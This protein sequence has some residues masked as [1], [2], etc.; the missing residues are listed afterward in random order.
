MSELASASFSVRD[1][2]RSGNTAVL[3]TALGLAAV[4]AVQMLSI[5]TGVHEA[6]STDDAM[7]LVEVRDLING[8][9]WFDLHQYRLNP[10]GLL[11]HWSRVIDFP[12]SISI[13]AL[14]PLLGM[15]RAESVTLFVWPL[16]LFG[17]ALA[18]I[19]AIARQ[20]SDGA[21][22]SQVGAVILAMLARPALVHFRPGAIDHHNAQ[23]DLLLLLILFTLQIERSAVKAALAGVA[24][25]LSLA[26]GVE[27]LPPIAAICVAVAGLFIWRGPAV[28]R[29]VAAFAIAL[30]GSSLVLALA[31]LPFPAM[32]APVCD[33]LGG[34]VL[35]LTIGGGIGLASMAAIDRYRSALWLRLVTGTV[36]GGAL[37]SAFIAL[38]GGCLEAP[39]AQLDPLVA[40]LWLDTV[41]ETISLAKMLRLGPEDVLG[42]YALPLI[43][44]GLAAGAL[45]RSKPHDRFRWIVCI[46][47]LIA[48]FGISVWE[49][50]GAGGAAMVA[51]P[52][53]AAAVTAIWPSL[54]FGSS[55]ALLALAGSS[56]AFAAFGVAAKPLT[57]LAFKADASAEET[58]KPGCSSVSDVAWMARLPKGRVMAPID[59][60]P[61]ILGTTSHDVFAGPYHRNNDGNSAMLKLMLAPPPV[62]HQMLSARQ[63]DYVVVCRAAP[64][65]N[66]IKRAPDGLEA[67]L[68]R[69][70]VPEF[71][72]PIDVGSA[73]RISAWRVRR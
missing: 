52:M 25:S 4:L 2:A 41:Q 56:T 40:S 21:L 34:P 55:L 44:L 32:A 69:G 49:M 26:V 43:T 33:T 58:L 29:Q 54:A 53:F 17:V 1:K 38:F 46:V 30:A 10:P 62:A 6:M 70:D 73:T 5:K 24:A 28:A 18:S 31:L 9:G 22:T 15:Y 14:K 48:Q 63:V 50:R 72:E 27:I 3:L 59:L 68:A 23:I 35:L 20:M 64:N 19:W 37:V 71:L 7:R 45:F 51:A 12:L 36:A 65:Q 60:G 16:L 13:L 11:M 42:F 39:Y 61:A 66:I 57:D 67:L 47:A 8:Q